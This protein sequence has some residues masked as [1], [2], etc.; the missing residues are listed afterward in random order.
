VS[1]ASRW[2]IAH[3]FWIIQRKKATEK[4]AKQKNGEEANSVSI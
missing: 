3:A 4:E 2:P 1:K